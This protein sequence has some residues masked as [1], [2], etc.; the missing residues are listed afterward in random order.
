MTIILS[1]QGQPFLTVRE[2]D[3]ASCD[4]CLKQLLCC[5]FK[6]SIPEAVKKIG[7]HPSFGDVIISQQIKNEEL[8]INCSGRVVKFAK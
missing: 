7:S 4:A 1:S 8:C 6:I 2:Q 5:C 3:S